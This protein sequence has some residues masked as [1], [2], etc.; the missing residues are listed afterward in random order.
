M[1]NQ[2]SLYEYVDSIKI[3]KTDPKYANSSIAGVAI[4]MMCQGKSDFQSINEFLEEPQYYSEILGINGIPS[5]PTF[6]QRLNE[7]SGQGLLYAQRSNIEL[8]KNPQVRFGKCLNE[9]VPIDLD[10]TPLD[11]GKTKKEGVSRTYKG[12]DGFAPMIAYMG[13]EGYAV[14]EELRPGSQHCQNGT[15]EFLKRVLKDAKKLTDAPLLV[16]MD[17]G[18]DSKENIDL[19][20]QR[21]TR[22]DFIIKRNLR[23]EPVD[24]WVALAKEE[25]AEKD[26]LRPRDGKEIYIGS[27]YRFVDSRELRIV[28]EVTIRTVSAD[29]QML[30]GPDIEVNTFWASL[31]EADEDG[32]SDA[33]VLQAYRD[34]AICEQF[35]SEIKT[36]MDLERLPSGSMG[37][38]RFIWALGMMAYNILRIMGQVS[39]KED[40][41]PLKRPVKRRRL[42]TVIQ[43]LITIAVHVVR[44]ARRVFLNLG[45]SNAWSRTYMRVHGILTEQLVL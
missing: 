17:S 38:N 23:Q 37:T 32:Y 27:T 15:V 20:F 8:L 6:R 4:A 7:I 14:G 33:E 39:L 31:P 2:T 35:H 34:H 42:K 18:N 9:Y 11:N 29:G 41:A 30:L 36:D 16:R 5:E 24:D 1:I 43:N 44:H 22:S 26:V 45:R 13:T 28:Y 19:C 21:D 40:D 25:V 12:C 3:S 10:V